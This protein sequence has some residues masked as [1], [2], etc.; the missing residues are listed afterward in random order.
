MIN[1]VINIFYN[2]VFKFYI[3]VCM[4][5]VFFKCEIFLVVFKLDYWYFI[6]NIRMVFIRDMDLLI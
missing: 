2:I 6:Y 3:I 4:F 5:Y 1:D